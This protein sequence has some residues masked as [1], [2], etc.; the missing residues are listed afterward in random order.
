MLRIFFI[1]MLCFCFGLSV[2][3]A[4]SNTNVIKE[5]IRTTPAMEKQISDLGKQ[6]TFTHKDLYNYLNKGLSSNDIKICYVVY[7]LSD[8]DKD[9]IVDVYLQEKM[10]LP[11]TLKDYEISHEDF[12]EKYDMTFQEEFKPIPRDSIPWRVAPPEWEL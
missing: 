10:D 9:E 8:K 2:T 7:L 5:H 6:T 4:N 11:L 3:M 12:K 1:T